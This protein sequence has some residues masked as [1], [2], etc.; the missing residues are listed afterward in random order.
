MARWPGAYAPR[1]MGECDEACGR[2]GGGFAAGAERRH[3]GLV[4]PG[5]S[6]GHAP[7]GVEPLRT[8]AAP[9]LPDYSTAGCERWATRT[10][11]RIASNSARRSAA[12]RRVQRHAGH[13]RARGAAGRTRALPD[14]TPSADGARSVSRVVRGLCV[15]RAA[16][17]PDGGNKGSGLIEGADKSF[18]KPVRIRYRLPLSRARIRA[19]RRRPDRSSLGRWRRRT[20]TAAAAQAA[21]REARVRLGGPAATMATQAFQRAREQSAEAADAGA[22]ADRLTVRRPRRPARRA[23]RPARRQRAP[24][25]RH[26][27]ALGRR[28]GRRPARARAPRRARARG[29]RRPT[30]ARALRELGL[31]PQALVVAY[32]PTSRAARRA[33]RAARGRRGR[34]ASAV[35]GRRTAAA[36]PAAAP[37]PPPAPLAS[38]CSGLSLDETLVLLADLAHE[39]AHAAGGG[40]SSSTWARAS[41]AR[42][43][44]GSRARVRPQCAAAARAD[45]AARRV[46]LRRGDDA[47][48]DGAAA[49]DVRVEIDDEGGAAGLG[50]ARGTGGACDWARGSRARGLPSRRPSAILLCAGLGALDRVLGCTGEDGPKPVTYDEAVGG[51]VARRTRSEYHAGLA[52]HQARGSA[53]LAA[54]AAALPPGWRARARRRR[55]RRAEPPPPPRSPSLPLARA[56]RRDERAVLLLSRAEPYEPMGR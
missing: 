31:E 40:A 4:L 29:T 37:A 38:P 12:P 52:R 39:L 14:G 25:R 22:S 20:R 26:A 11:T 33:R 21:V 55:R 6:H 7:R 17:A 1:T 45:A 19:E 47:A 36:A 53:R 50:G 10:A 42:E 28:L 24:G 3:V 51:P 16:A 18:I 27:A 2:A 34:R 44:D 9:R 5:R 41:A 46:A 8:A 15:C 32:T 30:T 35:G 48:A 54:A 43:E 56:P 23:A 49:A 13:E